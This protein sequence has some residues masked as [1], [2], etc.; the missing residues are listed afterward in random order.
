MLRIPYEKLALDY[1]GQLQQLKNRGLIIENEE[2]ALHLLENISYFRLSGYWYPMLATPKSS[3]VFK[4]GS[5]FTTVFKLYCFDKELRKL[6]L[7]ELEKIEI[8]IRAKIIYILS[9]RY[10]PFWFDDSS[11]FVNRSKWEITLNRFREDCQK[12]DEEFIKSFRRKYS[13]PI[14]PSWMI[15]EISSFGNLSSL[16]K[17]LK[18]SLAKREIAAHFGLDDTTFSSW[19][20][21][22]AY[23]RNVCAHHSRLWNRRM[24]VTP[25]IPLTPSQ[26][27]L[28]QTAKPN[29]I[30][31]RPDILLNSKVYFLLSMIIYLLNTINPQHSFKEKFLVLLKKYPN[32]DISAIGFPPEWKSEIIWKENTP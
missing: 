32:I 8:A 10:G 30:P 28:M 16:Y 5:S 24:G 23:I 22:M 17:N 1:A 25:K 19:L 3:H 12:S 27:W 13:D 14:P 15:L 20:H 2:K 11:L 26:T 29:P 4:P 18:P 9:H 31:G 6:V 7:N 21:N